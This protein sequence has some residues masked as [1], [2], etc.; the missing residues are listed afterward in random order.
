MAQ[1]LELVRATVTQV[2]PLKV[3]VDLSATAVTA[4]RVASYAAPAVG[5]R[6]RALVYGTNPPF[7]LGQ[8]V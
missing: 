8:E 1:Q 7:V 6:V 3:R 4:T 5:H 2:S